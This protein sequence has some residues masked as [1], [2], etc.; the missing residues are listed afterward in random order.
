MT[1][2]KE[3]KR[4]VVTPEGVLLG[5]TL[6][7][8]GDRAAAFLL[9]ALIIIGV[10]VALVLAVAFFGLL[11]GA[12]AFL[13]LLILSTFFL[14]SF[15]FTWFE[16]RWQGATPAK[17]LLGLRVI[18]RS[19]GPL[20]ADAVFARNLM[21]EIEVFIPLAVFL[22]PEAVWPGVPAWVRLLAGVWLGLLALL[23]F[24]NRDHLRVGDIVGGTMVVRAPR[25]V[26][27]EDLSS[28][29][30]VRRA[31]AEPAAPAFRFTNEQLDL[32]GIYELQVLEDLLRR[33]TP[34]ATL[35]EVARKIQAKIGW[36]AAP[37]EDLGAF[38]RAF[39]TAQRARLEQRLLLGDRRERKRSGRIGSTRKP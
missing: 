7:R 1:K 11:A 8:P 30:P 2:R 26:L 37:G 38:L 24:F 29:A 15:Y 22:A 27:L 34:A 17:R 18:D 21:R 4:D 31:G 9:D 20:T 10:G 32:Y 12:S 5:F 19:G 39:Y 25:V 28:E 13:I 14:R 33:P 3:L 6:A 35:D 23:P 36:S 16:C